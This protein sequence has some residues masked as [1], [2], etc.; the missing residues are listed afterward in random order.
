MD[1]N[2]KTRKKRNMIGILANVDAGKSTLCES[3]LYLA[4]TIRKQGRI[5]HG[6][7]F[8]DGDR[9][10]RR[11]GI[12][13]FS[14]QAS[15]EYGD[16]KVTLIDTPGHVDFSSE[17]ERTLGV[18]DYA[19][20]VISAS[21]GTE[22]HTRTLFELLTHYNVPFFVFLNKMD[23]SEKS[24]EELIEDLRA[25][26]SDR[27]VP[28]DDVSSEEFAEYMS[29]CS[30]DILNEYEQTG[31]ISKE[32]ISAAI[33]N[34][35][36]YPCFF[37]SALKNEGVLELIQ[38]L[39]E[40]MAEAEY[41]DE[42]SARVYKITRDKNGNRLTH[43]RLYG[44]KINVKDEI[45]GEKVEQIRV[46]NG[47]NFETVQIADRAGIY[48][49]VG[50]ESSFAGQGFGKNEDM[51]D[52]CLTPIMSY[53][54]ELPAN[55]DPLMAYKKLA[56]IEEED[57]QLSIYFDEYTKEIMVMV[58]GDIQVET[59]IEIVKDRFDMDISLVNGSISYRETIKN[60]TIGVGH[61]EPLRHYAE[62]HVKMTPMP[63][64]TGIVI[65][66]Q[67][68]TDLLERNWQNL[69]LGGL[70]AKRHK[71]ALV[72]AMLTDVKITL[73]A[74]RAHKK[75]TE[76]QD[77]YKAAAR[78]VR[79][80]L[81]SCES[82]LLEPFYSYKMSVPS[83][84][85]GRAMNDIK[86][87]SGSFDIESNENGICV[88]SG[89]CPVATMREYPK[90]LAAYTAGTG[91][92]SFN[93]D[94]YDECHN[95]EEV[96]EMKAYD[97]E[98]D[99]ANPSSSVFCSNG[100]GFVVPWNE[101]RE[102]MHV[103]DDGSWNYGKDE[104]DDEDEQEKEKTASEM[105]KEKTAVSLE[106]SSRG[107]G[108]SS[109]EDKELA[110]IF[111]KTYRSSKQKDTYK[112]MTVIEK[113]EK[114]VRSKCAGNEAT[115]E[116][117]LVDGY[118]IIFSWD[119]LNELSKQ[120]L[121]AARSKLADELDNY[122]AFKGVKLILVFDA[123]KVAGGVEK[124][125]AY[126]NITIVYTKEA[127]TADRYIEKTVHEIGRKYRCTVA[128]SD[129]TEQ[130]IIWAN[131]ATRMSARELFE[132]IEKTKED[133]RKIIGQK[134]REDT[135]IFIGLTEEASRVIEEIRLGKRVLE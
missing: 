100:K 66:S 14:K 108:L 93:S 106:T 119:R 50:L 61:F 28:F 71:G 74:G 117:L 45:C 84:H 25:K 90:E 30:E 110:E 51:K 126:G 111:N 94:G 55:A 112:P 81:M 41:S 12:T 131:G 78:A 114:E 36:V 19:I 37:G 53:K 77:F 47:D 11:R 103:E 121:E 10:E 96:I 113:N 34:R 72:G 102:H 21:D 58:M 116:W 125:F 48:T 115:E 127:E 62:V 39:T 29:L 69:I 8:L 101:V 18:L 122:S 123:Y 3:F 63:R 9:M 65:E 124:T 57:P 59:F 17:M 120:N 132:E 6:D 130:V 95:T 5:D 2:L 99:M 79:Q 46:Y 43:I 76:G 109:A 32:V 98:R 88:L 40:Y 44:G 80:G 86:R 129:A 20:L 118:N 4:G 67:L 56:L 135:T 42:F 26:L 70:R 1:D 73:I 35:E 133:I 13:I 75:H 33:K 128:T 107:I 24:K 52:V 87:M 134:K 7:S 83:I 49:L 68:S 105:I 54:I 38:G 82:I 31:K 60:E 104:G 91:Y 97:P 64:G 16:T 22:A 15:F 92:I 27:C 23:I 89:R 85:L